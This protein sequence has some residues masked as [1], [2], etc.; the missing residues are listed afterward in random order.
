MLKTGPAGIPLSIA[1]GIT[2]A[3][4]IGTILATPLPKASRGLL[5]KGKSHAAGGIPIEAEGGEA[6]INKKSTAMYGDLLSAINVA[7]GG[8]AFS[9]TPRFTNDGGYT[10]R[11]SNESSGI[12]KE[13]IQDAMER[14]VAKINVRIA[15]EDIRKADQN[16]TDVQAR[17]TF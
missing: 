9:S 4:E 17:G 5:L 13:D 11:K 15:I 10:A 12:S 6:I 16:Y 3:L 1:A 14:A 7:G 8:I 2:G